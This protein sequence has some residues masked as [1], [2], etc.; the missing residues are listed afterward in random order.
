M[1][2]FRFEIR[3]I[4]TDRLT[5]Y[6]EDLRLIMTHPTPALN[7][8]I[9]PK[10]R[11]IVALDVS[12][13]D[14]ASAIIDELRD[15][16]SAFKI[17]LQLFTAAG[18]QFVRDVVKSGLRVFLDLKF[19]DIPNTVA[20]AAVEAARLGVW[21]LNV[22]A[23][24]GGE[25]MRRTG[26]DVREVCDREGLRCPKLIAVTLLTSMD[27]K[28]LIETGIDDEVTGHV[29]RLANLTADSGFDGVVAS[30]LEIRAV[31]ATV[32]NSG[33]LIVTPG[34]RPNSETED[35][36]KRVTSFAQAVSD[37]TDFAVVG[38]P[39]TRAADRIK[40]VRQMLSEIE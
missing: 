4:W 20:M 1:Q 10:D 3:L 17:G 35:D 33:F 38:R 30:P 23:S 25:M 26:S 39:I 32:R 2:A 22:H 7:T 12:G 6:L 24:G 29:A 21:M 28:N 14:T 13:R 16:V 11:L 27:R 34:I 5:V 36:Q 18:P 9:L 40:A 15:E 37:G 31:R 8:S 19:H